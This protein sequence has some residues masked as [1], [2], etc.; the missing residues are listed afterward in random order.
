MD[1]NNDAA[2]DPPEHDTVAVQQQTLPD[3]GEQRSRQ[4]SRKTKQTLG[5]LP[6]P[7]SVFLYHKLMNDRIAQF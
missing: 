2:F 3:I 6:K 5:A 4:A 1:D 7:V